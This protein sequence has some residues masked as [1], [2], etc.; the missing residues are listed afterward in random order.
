MAQ[1]VLNLQEESFEQIIKSLS[2]HSQEMKELL[3]RATEKISALSGEWDDE[4]FQNL[5]EA[6]KS[7]GNKFD[8][9]DDH[10]QQMIA[11]AEY[12][13]EMIRARKSIKL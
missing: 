12:K 1:D 8:D 2:Q 7:I 11:K 5:L 6:M 10:T 3:D 4:D 9:V 13:L